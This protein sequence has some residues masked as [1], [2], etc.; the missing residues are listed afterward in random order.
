MQMQTYE[1]YTS[2]ITSKGV[3]NFPFKTIDNILDCIS[4]GQQ[5]HNNEE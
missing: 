4:N 5:E 1:N 3:L 2:A